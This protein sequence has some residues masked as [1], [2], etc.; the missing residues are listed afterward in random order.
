MYSIHKSDNLFKEDIKKTS[1]RQ[2]MEFQ[3]FLQHK[4]VKYLHD[5]LNSQQNIESKINFFYIL[6][7]I[8]LI[9]LA[10]VGLVIIIK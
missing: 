5:Q 7:V 2:L 1:D 8:Q 4:Q 3:C 6:V 10:L 9:I